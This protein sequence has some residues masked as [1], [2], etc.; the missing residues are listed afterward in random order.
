MDETF[1]ERLESL[2]REFA[3]AGDRFPGLR[4]D[5]LEDHSGIALHNK[6][7]DAIR[8]KS[9]CGLQDTEWDHFPDGRFLARFHGNLKGHSEFT[10]L[11]KRAYGLFCDTDTQLVRKDSHYGWIRIIYDMAFH[12]PSSCVRFERK[13]WGHDGPLDYKTRAELPDRRWKHDG[14]SLPSN[15]RQLVFDGCPFGI[16]VGGIADVSDP[17]RHGLLAE[18]D[19]EISAGAVAIRCGLLQHGGSST[20]G[21][22]TRRKRYS[23]TGR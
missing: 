3:G 13:F 14:I 17:A 6:G 19:R 1:K 22:G 5:L 23:R 11:A 2:Q 10:R 15:P 9:R 4:L 7:W 8:K 18:R 20:S 12:C 21:L 16:S